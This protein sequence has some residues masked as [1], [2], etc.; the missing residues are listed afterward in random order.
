MLRTYTCVNKYMAISRP[1]WSL[2][3]AGLGNSPQWARAL[4]FTRFLH[5]TQRRATVGRTPLEEWSARRR[6]LYLTTQYSQETDIHI[7]GGIRTQSKSRRA[8]A[9]SR[10]RSRDHWDHPRPFKYI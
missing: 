3:M 6:D 5:H 9:D 1:F 10:L 7:A 4:S 2:E 8:A